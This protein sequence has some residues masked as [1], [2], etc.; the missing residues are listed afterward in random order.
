MKAFKYGVDTAIQCNPYSSL[1]G[2]QI[3]PFESPPSSPPRGRR[4]QYLCTKSSIIRH[5]GRQA[6]YINHQIYAVRIRVN[7]R[8]IV[9]MHSI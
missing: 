7:D 9:E 6:I 1:G 8:Q 3:D 4:A 5:D 2:H